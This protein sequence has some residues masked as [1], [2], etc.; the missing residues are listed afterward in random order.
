MT[1]VVSIGIIHVVYFVIYLNDQKLMEKKHFNI[2]LLLFFLFDRL[3]N[4]NVGG[5]C[6]NKK[7]RIYGTS[8]LSHDK[9]CE[10]VCV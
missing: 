10:A 4:L 7:S 5:A 8:D 2:L 9:K 3:V 6:L 1:C